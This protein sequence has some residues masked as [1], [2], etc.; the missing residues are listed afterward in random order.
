MIFVDLETT[1]AN[2]VYDRITEIGI[3][4]VDGERITRW[5]TLVN[6]G[7]SI[8]PFIQNLTG[9]TNEMVALAPSFSSL[10]KELQQRLAGGLFIAHNVRFDYGFLRNEFKLAGATLRCEILCTVKLSRKLFPHEAR[11]NLD[12][13]VMRHRLEA[14]DRHRALTDADLL[15]QFWCRLHEEVAHENL[16]A[17]IAQLL[18][19]PSL[20]TL[21]DADALEDIPNTP[22]VYLFYGK[23]DALLYVGKSI[24]LRQRVLSHFNADHR[25]H[26]DMRLS[27]QIDRLEWRE[28]A[29]EIGA[30]LLEARL[31]KQHKPVHNRLLRVQPEL[32]SWQMRAQADG[33]MRPVLSFATD[34]DFG[35]AQDLY[36]LFSSRRKAEEAL[37]ELTD[38]HQLCPAILGLEIHHPGKPCFACQL[39][40]CR[41]ACT[42]VESHEQHHARVAMAL[43]ALQVRS[44]PHAGA[45]G[46]IEH[47]P[48]G[49]QD[50]HV[51]NNWC[52]LGTVQSEGEAHELIA[53]SP[54]RPTFD[55]DNYKLLLRH[56]T[57]GLLEIRDLDGQSAIKAQTS[58]KTGAKLS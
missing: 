27:Q 47:G 23:N 18:Q 38:A 24:H 56:V 28:T 7:I 29:G 16:A 52:W 1:G 31:I 5:S 57:R 20:P 42:G 35:H 44:W 10:V 34:Q 4:E 40:R 55:I 2:V 48:K 19:R 51:I 26:K 58:G 45:I 32:C 46:L 9:I 39:R 30:L 33:R 17:A 6:P 43:S 13:L 3:V 53:Q 11:H 8:P 41:G 21:L 50:I 36:G 49:R 22:G 12:A 37:R 14:Q 25:V 15:W 54:Q